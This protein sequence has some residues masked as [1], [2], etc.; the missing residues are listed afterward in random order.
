MRAEPTGQH[1]IVGVDDLFF[2]TTDR[3]GVIQGANTVFS[4]LAAFPR[5]ELVG[6]PHNIIRH[7]EMPGGAFAVMW[8]LLLSGR[9]M[10]AYVKN[11]AKD[12]ATYW[13]FATIT[14]LGDS[15]LSVRTAPS[16]RPL[17]EA[18]STLYD[19]VLPVERQARAE[20]KNRHE[21]AALGAA[22]L[23]D[24]IAALGFASYD[25]FIRAAL[26]MEVAARA[27]QSRLSARRP[28][29]T[30]DLGVLLGAVD[31]IDTELTGLLARLDSFQQLAE[32]L[33]VASTAATE[34]IRGLRDATAMA[35]Q[36][37]ES[38]AS[39]AP[40][41]SRAA[42][43]MTVRCLE[44]AE[45]I[46]ELSEQLT[47]VRE[48]LLELRFRISLARLHDDMVMAFALEVLDGKAPPEGLGY[49]PPLCAALQEGLEVVARDMAL[50]ATTLRTV[51]HDI[52]DAG[53]RLKDFQ[54]LTATWRL[55]VPRYQ[56]SRQLDPYVAPIDAQLLVGHRQMAGLRDLAR[57]CVAEA[58]PFDPR[59]L[60]GPVAQIE[61]L[62]RR[63]EL[64]ATSG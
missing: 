21:A 2:S 44:T 58:V 29:A 39:S 38:V 17:W 16:C 64:R 3:R 1:R 56:M 10:G 63:Q 40:V 61:Q 46:D 57:R 4:Q 53:E 19:A 35:S 28:D 25:A 36:A 13:V 9:P 49:I 6:A 48:W 51:A 23:A 60:L 50:V 15:F 11:L 30:G 33:A 24:G 5:D 47:E 7:P 14:P 41:L 37:S 22:A 54:R 59:P 43:A 45:R 20:G 26:P 8:D 62:S 27:A 55:L 34:T 52:D 18:A 31:R 42:G 12:G 32:A